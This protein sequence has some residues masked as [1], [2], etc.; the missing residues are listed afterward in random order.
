M[1]TPENRLHL[2]VL[3]LSATLVV[4]SGSTWAMSCAYDAGMG[5]S[6]M[7]AKGT[8]MGGT[9]APARG[10]G[11]G[12]T[13]VSEG[14]KAEMQ[15]A[16]SI[17]FSQGSVVAQR[18]GKTRLLAKGDAVCVG[19]TLT[20][21]T[22]GQVQIRMKDDAMVAVRPQTSLKIE[23]YVYVGNSQDGS[24][25]ALRHGA[26]RMVTGRI[27]HAYPQNDLIR[28]PTATIGVRGTD[29]EAA[30]ILPGNPEGYAPGTYDRVNS[31]VTFIRT[32][33]GEVDIHP[34]QV[35]YVGS[36]GELPALL[37]EV[38]GFYE[39]NPAPLHEE[40]LS[41]PEGGEEANHAKHEGAATE[42]PG[43]PPMEHPEAGKVEVPELPERPEAP[44]L[45]D[46][47]HTEH[48]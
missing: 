29:H 13:G 21:G 11:M 16:G 3:L 17:T 1:R 24:L 7:T 30:V 38:P 20:T 25:L 4:G 35:G 37:P 44:E 41:E 5:G 45:P 19:E 47:D 22:S 31:G 43:V 10:T 28:T 46:L 27:G 36:A 6:G 42:H 14:D 2:G 9:G 40:L 33:K 8:G 26:L 18:D 12:G 15:L 48:H 34:A 23:K 32:E 39:A